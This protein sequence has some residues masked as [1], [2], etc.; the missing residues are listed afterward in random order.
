M[1]DRKKHQTH[2]DRRRAATAAL[3]VL[4]ALGYSVSEINLA[5]TDQLVGDLT[6]FELR[7]E[8]DHPTG[9]TS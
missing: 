7:K 8:I 4:E 5:T 6:P 3:Q 1:S 2:L 9:E